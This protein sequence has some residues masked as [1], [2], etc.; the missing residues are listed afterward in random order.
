MVGEKADDGETVYRAGPAERGLGTVLSASRWLLAPFYLLLV[1]TLA[2]LLIKALQ[3]AWHFI[4]HVLTATE[5]EVI[6][7][8][9]A[10]IDLTFTG[11]LIVIVIFSGYENFVAKIDIGTSRNWPAWMSQIDF[12]GLKLKLISCI[13]AISAI[14]LLKAF[15]NV[16]G[17]SDRDLMWYVVVHVVFVVSGVLMA[18]TDRISGEA[19][20]SK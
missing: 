14:Q 19:K 20:A 3:E 15:M 11:S 12:S 10:L 13:V 16:K 1:V 7:G 5:A 6:L 17:T 18:W 9:L 2:G 8:V 4:S